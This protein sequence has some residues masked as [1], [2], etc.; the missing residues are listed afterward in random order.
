LPDA[1]AAADRIVER[2]LDW[3]LERFRLSN[4]DFYSAYQTARVIV[5]AAFCRAGSGSQG[6]SPRQKTN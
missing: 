1:I 6:G 3:L 5:D 4:G 2:Q